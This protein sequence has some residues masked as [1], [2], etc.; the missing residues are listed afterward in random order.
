MTWTRR[1]W[2]RSFS[3]SLLAVASR[4][5]YAHLGTGPV[6]PL[7]PAPDAWVVDQTGQRRRL[8]D[9]LQGNVTALQTMFT[10]CSS[11]CPLQG[12]MFG[13]VQEG[14]PRLRGRY[15]LRL[16]SL[17]IDP[18]SDTPKALHEWLQRMGAGPSWRGAVPAGDVEKLRTALAGRAPAENIDRH[19]TQVYF[20]NAA[21]QLCWRSP[22]LPQPEEVLAVMGHLAKA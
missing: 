17:S 11:V 15:P 14:L 18:L 4:D 9:M 1:A 16:V 6:E 21:A 20:F 22:P 19:S 12:A 7:L 3:A 5:L 10:G 8:A 2:L 13:A